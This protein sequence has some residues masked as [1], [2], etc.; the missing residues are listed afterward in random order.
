MKNK[1]I[2]TTIT[3]LT[4]IVAFGIQNIY[5]Q[6]TN[7]FISTNYILSDPV[8]GEAGPYVSSPSFKERSTLGQLI[9]GVSQSTN[10]IL[11]SGFEYYSGQSV[12]SITMSLNTNLINF[13]TVAPNTIVNAPISTAG[14]QTTTSL[15]QATDRARAVEYNGYVYEIGGTV[16]ST[17]DYAHILPNGTLGPWN[18][19]TS[20]PAGIMNATSVVYNG[21]VYEIGGDN[22]SAVVATIDYAPINTNG[23][24]GAWTS[25]TPLPT[26]TQNATSV[27]YNGYVYEIGGSN[28][29]GTDLSIV[30]YAH[31]LSN[32]TIGSWITTTSLPIAN[33][34]ATSIVYNGYMYEI[35]GS[36]FGN[37]VDYT[38]INSNG[39][40]GSW[41]ATTSFP[42]TTMY[43]TSVEY[44]SYVYEIGGE[45]GSGFITTIDYA[46]I[47]SNGTLGT[48]VA[49][50]PLPIAIFIATSV[51]YNGY[52]YEIGGSNSAGTALSTVYYFPIIS[53]TSIITVSSNAESGYNLYISQNNNLTNQQGDTIPPVNNGA[54]TTTAALW[55]SASYYGLGY[56]C[57]ASN[58]YKQAVL[59]NSP[60]G[61]WSLGE[62]SGTTA[63]DLS[64]NS[65]NGTYTGGYT[66]GEQGPISNSNLGNSTLLNGANGYVSTNYVQNNIT[67]YTES[68]WVKTTS[69]VGNPVIEDRGS[70][71]GLSI[72]MNIGFGPQG[73]HPGSVNCG[74]DT[75]GTWIGGYTTQTINDGKWHNV[76]CVFTSTSG[77]TITPA[78]FSVYIDGQ[79]ASLT[80][81]TIGSATSPVSGLGGTIIGNDP[82]WSPSYFTGMISN[83]SIYTTA[84][85]ST[86]I[87]TLF[88]DGI[89]S[90]QATCNSDFINSNYYRQLS[91]TNT[92][93]ASYS[94]IATNQEIAVG[95]AVN[96][97]NIQASGIY[98]N[99]ITYTLT[100]N[101]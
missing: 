93:F 98:T 4:F 5:A 35:G 36:G 37:T 27:V 71:S 19:T 31:I 21:Y 46:P 100:G 26:A 56:N 63:Y 94:S 76:V 64:G 89:N 23:T 43:A 101:Y 66:Q 22:G 38:I 55:T 59:A 97:S 74:L 73:T 92:E 96:V 70:G 88:N 17:V 2:F 67:Q 82:N 14:V 32:G 57:S 13:N 10:F 85:T 40:L 62:T 28:S 33:H 7:N 72:T 54:T 34:G 44:N 42:V 6:T 75:A 77:S 16:T 51:V 39:T 47:L 52:V 69:N 61:F 84:L 48:W 29:A 86:Q 11:K 8:F 90:T 15:L 60:I 12:P 3:I 25:T 50:T 1:I 83:V 95:Y 79:N 9:T 41:I 24:L 58:T 18:A 20:L 91:T 80:T 81:T 49:T 53:A 30:D 65:N 68:V 87:Q 99:T 45:S 78:D